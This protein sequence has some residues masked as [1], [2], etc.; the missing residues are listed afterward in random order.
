MGKVASPTVSNPQLAP[1]G[2][3]A[4]K[5]LEHAQL[6][7]RIKPK[8]VYGENVRQTLQLFDSGNADA[9]LT[10]AGLVM[11]RNPQMIPADWHQPIVQ[12]AGIVTASAKQKAAALFLRFLEG[13][14]AQVIFAKHGFGKPTN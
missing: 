12:K 5:A 11:E 14:T 10:A 8:V 13:P 2:E 1:Y 7:A 3:A 4:Q 9:V 6:C